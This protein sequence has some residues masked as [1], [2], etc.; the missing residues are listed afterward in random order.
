[1]QYIYIFRF[2]HSYFKLKNKQ[3]MENFYFITMELKT[4]EKNFIAAINIS[5]K[6]RK[7][8]M[9]EIKANRKLIFLDNG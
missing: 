2:D 4:W 1:M 8:E 9:F 7:P 6:E 5:S 3:T